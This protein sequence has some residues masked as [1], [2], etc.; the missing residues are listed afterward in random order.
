MRIKMHSLEEVGANVPAFLAKLWKI[1]EDPETNDLIRWSA[2]GASF[3]IQNTARFS[4]ELLPLY[5]KHNNMASFIRQLNM[6]G[7]HKVVSLEAGGLKVDKDEM[8]FAHPCFVHDHPVLLENIKRKQIPNKLEGE[9]RLGARSDV[10]GK[11]L[12]EVKNMK[13][14]QESLDSQLVSMKREN[15]V[16]WREVALL[17]EKHKQQQTIVNKLVHF[18]VNLF[19][20]DEAGNL[21][22]KRQARLMIKDKTHSAAKVAKLDGFRSRRGHSGT[23]R[24]ASFVPTTGGDAE[25]FLRLDE[26]EDSDGMEERSPQGPIIHE[27]DASELLDGYSAVEMSEEESTA[28]PQDLREAVESADSRHDKGAGGPGDMLLDVCPDIT[29]SSLPLDVDM[30][31]AEATDTEPRAPAGRPRELKRRRRRRP[32]QQDDGLTIILPLEEAVDDVQPV[33]M[34]VPEPRQLKE[35]PGSL[36]A[37]TSAPPSTAATAASLDR[38][39]LDSHVGSMQSELDNIRELLKGEGYSLDDSTLMGVRAADQGLAPD[40]FTKIFS[41]DPLSYELSELPSGVESAGDRGKENLEFSSDP[42]ITGSELISSGSN[43]LPELTDFLDWTQVSEAPGDYELILG[44][45]NTPQMVPGS[46]GASK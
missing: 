37:A 11:V 6:Y 41:D 16:L 33:E 25:D 26:E 31:I 13:G 45:L 46:P 22:L 38:E 7:F 10:Y 40:V 43:G 3:I 1:V 34:I 12:T 14:R 36:E 20:A 29:V 4:R 27:I 28:L 35:E 18:F 15:E 32:A 42:L 5:Y 44:D 30:V 17:R 19:Q 39:Q 8:E 23:V 21:R 2:E 24:K 9:L